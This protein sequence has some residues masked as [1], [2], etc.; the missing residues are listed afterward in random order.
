MKTIKLFLYNFFIIFFIYLLIFSTNKVYANTY[1][2]EN[3]EISD[4]Y[5][6]DFNKEN[7]INKAFQRA[8]SILLGKITISK[9]YSL[10]ENQNLRLIKSFVD[11]FSVVSEKFENKKYYGVFEVN[12]NKNKVITFLRNKN[13]FHSRMSERNVLFIP[14]LVDLEKN[15]LFLFDENPFYKYW[16]HEEENQFLLK[17][18]LQNEDLDD[19][20]LIQDRINFIENYDFEEIISKYELNDNYIIFIV[21]KDVENLKTFSKF[22]VNSI[23]SNFK[24]EFPKFKFEEKNKIKELIRSMK[25]KYDDEWKKI[26]LI[27]TSIKLNIQLNVDSKNIIL[28]EK[29]EKVLSQIELIEKY[30]IS[31]FNN[32]ITSYSILS[33]STPDKLIKELEKFNFKISTENNKW[34][35]NE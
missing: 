14:I 7:I 27:N 20:K 6:V 3:I 16:N 30:Y 26:N 18:I 2:I 11:S 4:E 32:E 33:N 34:V 21:F 19:Y 31:F 17:Y 15:S 29:I 1:K 23:K 25:I 9:D 10:I 35:L 8:F 22:N 28:I 13:I 24:I 5:N 12:F